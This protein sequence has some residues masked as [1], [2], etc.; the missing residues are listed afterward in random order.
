MLICVHH[1]DKP[2]PKNR[3]RTTDGDPIVSSAMSPHPHLRLVTSD[4]EPEP[5]ASVFESVTPL[6]F[7]GLV[8]ATIVSPIVRAISETFEAF[9]SG[10]DLD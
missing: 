6:T 7:F 9:E 5:E 1:E 3:S 4:P 8:A 2:G 10:A